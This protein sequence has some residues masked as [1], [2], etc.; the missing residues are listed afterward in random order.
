MGESGFELRSVNELERSK[1]YWS[2]EVSLL[3]ASMLGAFI[4]SGYA[5]L[6]KYY[7]T[8]DVPIDRMN[9]SAQKLAAYGG[10]GLGATIAAIL[11][12]VALVFAFT[13]V[14]AL[15]EEPGK[16]LSSQPNLSGWIFR[17]RQRASELSVPLKFLIASIV[18]AGFASFAWYITVSIPSESGRNAALKT[19]AKCEERT[20]EYRNLDS[21]TACQV[22]E[23]DDMFYLLKREHTDQSGVSFRTFQVPKAGLLKSEGQKQYLKYKP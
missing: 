7:L 20:L 6:E 5:H 14:I 16:K 2:V 19:A 17:R 12:S 13:I 11:L 15:S 1:K 22:A 3:I 23:S 10:A 18:L 9:F 21:Y 4:L 8:L